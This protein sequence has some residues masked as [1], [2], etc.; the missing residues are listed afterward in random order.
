MGWDLIFNE[1]NIFTKLVGTKISKL[2]NFGCEAK[3]RKGSNRL[4]F[5]VRSAYELQS[6]VHLLGMKQF[7]NHQD[8]KYHACRVWYTSE[9]STDLVYASCG[10]QVH[11]TTCGYDIVKKWRDLQELNTL[12]RVVLLNILSE[13]SI[14]MARPMGEQFFTAVSRVNKL[15]D[16]G[17]A[18]IATFTI[19]PNLPN[20]LESLLDHF[21]ALHGHSM[22]DIDLFFKTM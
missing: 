14:Y 11:I 16:S 12:E 22:V 8:S 2:L 7:L 18:Q 20:A 13:G 17:N 9:A 3:G 21:K 15:A 10:L 4:V 6:V 1:P 5:L 19:Q